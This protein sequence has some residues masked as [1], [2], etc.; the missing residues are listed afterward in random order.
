M[1]TLFPPHSPSESGDFTSSPLDIGADDT[2]FFC[3]YHLERG[4]KSRLGRWPGATPPPTK[5]A[6]APAVLLKAVGALPDAD[7]EVMSPE[8]LR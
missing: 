5:R 4:E 6:S 3:T 1:L 8:P 2:R 7:G